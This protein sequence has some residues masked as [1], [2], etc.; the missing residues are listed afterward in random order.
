MPPVLPRLVG[1]KNFT[2]VYRYGRK[3][4]TPSMMVNYL[5]NPQEVTKV[6]VVVS[7]RVS[8]L[9]TQRN[10]YKRRLWGCLR[11]HRQLIPAGYYLIISARPAIIELT[12]KELSLQI[13]SLLRKIS[14]YYE[15]K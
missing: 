13:E 12:Y 7:R 4:Y 10:L 14:S 1:K 2:N 9:A 15:K 11:E 3:L 8:K 6:A 5:R